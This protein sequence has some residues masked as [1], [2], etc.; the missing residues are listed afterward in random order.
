MVLSQEAIHHV[1][2]SSLCRTHHDH[3]RAQFGGEFENV[4]RA[5]AFGKNIRHVEEHKR[6]QAQCDHRRCQYQ[7]TREMSHVQHQ[8]NRI[9]TRLA[10]H[11][12][13]QHVD[14]D[15]FIVGI[16]R[17]AIDAG[18]ID[19]PDLGPFTGQQTYTLLNRYAGVI[20]DLLAKAGQT[21]EER[22]LP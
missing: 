21:I 12:T 14:G 10:V 16:R 20:A 18:Q 22:R 17:Q 1:Q 8:Q 2:T 4:E 11:L 6:R 7:L 5:A 3:R 19:D 9:G 15:A 13:G